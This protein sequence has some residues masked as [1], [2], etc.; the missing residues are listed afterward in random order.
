[1]NTGQASDAAQHKK[2]KYKSPDSEKRW[3][4]SHL[5]F[6]LTVDGFA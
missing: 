5:F 6:A 1:M 4:Y 2:T 3:Y